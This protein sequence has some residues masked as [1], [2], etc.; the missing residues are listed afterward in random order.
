MFFHWRVL[1]KPRSLARGEKEVLD[2]AILC[3]VSNWHWTDCKG[4]AT[5]KSYE[6]N[7]LTFNSWHVDACHLRH[8]SCDFHCK[9]P[10]CGALCY[11]FSMDQFLWAIELLSFKKK[12]ATPVLFN[13]IYIQLV[14][15]GR[16][17]IREN[18][19]KIIELSNLLQPDTSFPSGTL[20]TSQ[21]T[22]DSFSLHNPF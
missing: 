1:H 6:A 7:N 2:Q 22:L 11:E 18:T 16:K 9:F 15:K 8:G 4:I 19:L 14:N 10:A 20:Y 5:N 21:Q 13:G 3:G 17:T 12:K